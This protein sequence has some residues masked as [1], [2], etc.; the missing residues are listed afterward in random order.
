MPSGEVN[1]DQLIPFL[2]QRCGDDKKSACR[3]D[4]QENVIG[5]QQRTVFYDQLP[6]SFVALMGTIA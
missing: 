4:C 6:Q 3:A 1:D 5:I 2:Q